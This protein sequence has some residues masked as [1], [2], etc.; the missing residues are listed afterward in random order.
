MSPTPRRSPA[1]PH[2]GPPPGRDRPG[3]GRSAKPTRASDRGLVVPGLGACDCALENATASSKRSSLSLEFRRRGTPSATH[4]WSQRPRR[5][6]GPPRQRDGLPTRRPSRLV[7][8]AG[9]VQGPRLSAA[10]GRDSRRASSRRQPVPRPSLT[11][12]RTVPELPEPA[13][14][15]QHGFGL[16]V[17]QRPT[18]PPPAGWRARPPAGPAIVP[19][20]PGPPA[21]AVGATASAR[22]GPRAASR[23]SSSSS[24]RRQPL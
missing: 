14:H 18:P 8:S 12:A 23:I 22:S 6:R 2:P 17:H 5:G 7:R 11:Q 9:P 21:P 19:L 3:R 13:G 15:P 20:R 4:R 10:A 24:Q 1:P 16:G